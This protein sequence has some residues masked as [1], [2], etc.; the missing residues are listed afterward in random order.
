[1]CIRDSNDPDLI[2]DV[3]VAIRSTLSEHG[4][5]SEV[6]EASIDASMG[7]FAAWGYGPEGQPDIYHPL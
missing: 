6:I 7:A 3:N 1:M 4:I 2:R 5:A